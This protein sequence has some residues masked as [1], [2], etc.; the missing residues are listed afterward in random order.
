[1]KKVD[2]KR[3]LPSGPSKG[4]SSLIAT[5][6]LVPASNITTKTY[7]KVDDDIKTPQQQDL[8]EQTTSLKN[9]F[10]LAEKLFGE[11]TKLEKRKTQRQRIEK[12]RERRGKKE[13]EIESRTFKFGGKLPTLRLP[14]T[15]FLD[16]I[17]RFV[18]YSVLGLA[19][20]KIIPIIPKLTSLAKKITPV[21]QFFTNTVGNIVKNTAEFIDR[22]YKA[23]D[24]LKQKVDN[25]LP[26]GY[27]K[28]FDTFTDNLTEVISG[29]LLV[30]GAILGLKGGT[31]N[32]VKEALRGGGSLASGIESSKK[33]F[34][35][36]S[37]RTVKD[38][39]PSFR[40]RASNMMLRTS[41]G[42]PRAKDL[43]T[44]EA[45]KNPAFA[46]QYTPQKASYTSARDKAVVN[47]IVEGATDE[48]TQA[49]RRAGVG[50]LDDA[51][52]R[53]TAKNL[54]RLMGFGN[55]VGPNEPYKVEK[56]KRFPKFDQVTRYKKF[57]KRPTS[58]QSLGSAVSSEIARQKK[59]FMKFGYKVA[60]LVNVAEGF[61][62]SFGDD[63]IARKAAYEMLVK[64]G[65]AYKVQNV[66]DL[67]IPG[68]KEAF[69]KNPREATRRILESQTFRPPSI[70]RPG[71]GITP[72]VLEQPAALPR[73]G[74]IF[75]RGIRRSGRRLAIK[76]GGKGTARLLGKVPIIGPLIDFAFNVLAGDSPTRAAAG[77]AGAAAGAALGSAIGSV[78]PLAG[79]LLG[80]IG[81][82]ILGDILGKSLYDSVLQIMNKK[83]A[84]EEQKKFM[85]SI[86][87]T[88]EEEKPKPY[89]FAEPAGPTV[90][91][92]S[93][94]P[95]L[96]PTNTI[97]GQNYG[98]PRDGGTRKHAG[99]DFDAGPTDTFYSRIGGKVIKIG[100]DPGGYGN[101]VDIYNKDLNVVERI[102]EGDYN[103]VRLGDMVQPGDAIQT[104]TS[105]TGVFHYEIRKGSTSSFGFQGTVNP[106][107]FLNRISK[108][109]KQANISKPNKSGDIASLTTT[110]D[111]GDGQTNVII[112]PTTTVVNDPIVA[113]NGGGGGSLNSSIT[114]SIFAS[115]LVG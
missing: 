88:D 92:Q 109:K 73:P 110:P 115:S 11:K 24:F 46:L 63:P 103:H 49:L 48:T 34:S 40:A 39:A 76:I 72:K 16:T 112:V 27:Q 45:L 104:G 84:T 26:E 95:A 8:K 58:S 43:P 111:Y 33:Y 98:A 85:K 82:G 93:G 4:S 54:M 60:D 64:R 79:T 78:I 86:F 56:S 19:V 108:S 9:K 2:P 105:Q 87:G 28:T 94:L 13:Q 17:R 75:D 6:F 37:F 55:T 44:R 90:I 14:R 59:V 74:G 81:G 15:G 5:N 77:A 101:Y 51:P 96:P 1:M 42:M 57:V 22:G 18:L 83:K 68:R 31:P 50:V 91:D 71:E 53:N 41:L 20:D 61:S 97:P 38:T 35:R 70:P 102:A 3:L 62:E 106:I 52:Q 7:A 66:P 12:E 47:S 29:T 25:I 21:L 32:A 113:S 69:I 23:A 100:V 107:D 36:Y 114:S 10:I 80:G 65:Y 89:T 99:V 30:A 67:G